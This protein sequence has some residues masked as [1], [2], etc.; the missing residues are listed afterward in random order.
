MPVIALLSDFGTTEPY[1]AQ[2][3]GVILGCCPEA[4]IADVTHAVEPY[5]LAQAAFF[6]ASTRPWYPA[7]TIFVAVVDPGVGSER[8]VVLLEKFGQRFI[9]PDNGL[10][11]L[12]LLEPAPARAF[13]ISGF[14]GSGAVSSTFHG[15]DIM[16]P[17]AAHLA[18]GGRPEDLG[19]ALRPGDLTRMDWAAPKDEHDTVEAAVL[20]VDRFGNC[21]LNLPCEPWAKRL[22]KWP[23]MSVRLPAKRELRQVAARRPLR[24]VSARRP[25]RQVAAYSDLDR[26]EIGLLAGSQGFME[27][28]LNRSEA[29]RSLGLNAGMSLVLCREDTA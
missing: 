20:H 13:D 24:Q 17:A 21:L 11:S 18:K 6:L 8:R 25:L 3:R 10:L 9:A 4:V 12:L 7:E 29:A 16:A 19:S 2:M 5:N 14:K 15:R 22:A 27:L 26:T 1:V 28:C 23:G